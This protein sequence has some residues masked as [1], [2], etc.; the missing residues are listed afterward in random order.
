AKLEAHHLSAKSLYYLPEHALEH[1]FVIAG[2]RARRQDDEQ[3]DA[4]KALREM[5]SDGKLRAVV[6]ET[7]D[8]RLKAT[9]FEKRGPI[10]FIESTSAATIFGE[11]LTRCLI[12]DTDESPDQTKSI[13]SAAAQSAADGGNGDAAD[14]LAPIHHAMH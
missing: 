8:G 11:D 4:T 5:I 2:E 10:A 6:T 7:I 9:P 3:A 1:R 13:I 12:L 14:V